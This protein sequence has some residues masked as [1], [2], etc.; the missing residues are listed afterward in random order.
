MPRRS[1]K[2]LLLGLLSVGLWLPIS[3]QS[4]RAPQSERYAL[5]YQSLIVS[6]AR[7]QFRALGNLWRDMGH[8]RA[9]LPAYAAALADAPNVTLALQLAEFYLQLEAPDAALDA[10]T[11]GYAAAPRSTALNA[12][13]G[14]LLAPCDPTRALPH[15][16]AVGFDDRYDSATLPLLSLIRR[17][18]ALVSPGYSARVGAILMS[19][20]LWA[21]AEH[22]YRCAAA[23]DPTFAEA[24][25]QIAHLRAQQGRSGAYWIA[26]ALALAPTSPD[27][28]LAQALML[29]RLGQPG[30]ALE[31][32][33]VARL[34]APNDAALY[35]ET[36]LTYEQ[37]GQA[38]AAAA[39]RAQAE[40]IIGVP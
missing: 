40:A 21:L 6:D 20:E 2:L 11:L 39:W 13:L 22:A 27:V 34:Y 36:A 5:L 10:L 30:A 25:A 31:A 26:Q 37:L 32:L 38:E 8:L 24:L 4:A 1:S 15:L 33:A 16:R 17:E 12:A 18:G 7:P 29:R 28:R 23:Q 3:A 9:S 19:A 35:L 14:F